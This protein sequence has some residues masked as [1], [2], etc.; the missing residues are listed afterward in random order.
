[1]WVAP[2]GGVEPGEPA[3]TALRR[4]L[5]EEVGLVLGTDPP[6]VGLGGLVMF[7]VAGGGGVDQE[8]QRHC[9]GPAQRVLGWQLQLRH[10]PVGRIDLG[11][12]V[13]HCISAIGEIDMNGYICQNWTHPD[14]GHC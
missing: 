3:L 8:V 10:G 14:P 7:R 12:D 1:V 11:R 13:N 4:E 2:G 6:H 5:L 9:A